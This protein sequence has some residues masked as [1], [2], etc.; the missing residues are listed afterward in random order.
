LGQ[1]E[2]GIA[3]RSS[4]FSY[5]DSVISTPSSQSNQRNP[6]LA[7]QQ[8]Q[9]LQQLHSFNPAC[10]PFPWLLEPWPGAPPLLSTIPK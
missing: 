1:L 9:Q 2:P 10:A 8:L 6:L 7:S 5:L 3:I 4:R